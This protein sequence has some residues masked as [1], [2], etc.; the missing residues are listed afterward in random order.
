MLE[1]ATGVLTMLAV[2][3]GVLVFG[4]TFWLVVAWLPF[5][6]LEW[7]DFLLYKRVAQRNDEHGEARRSGSWTP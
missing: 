6:L 1:I 4:I 3:G 5:K 7:W 2:L